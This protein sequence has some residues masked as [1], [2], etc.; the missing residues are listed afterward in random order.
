MKGKTTNVVLGIILVII[1]IGYVGN[2]FE[3]WNFKL[4]FPGWWTLFI[5]IPA[6][7]KLLRHGIKPF[8][9]VLL[10]AGILLLLNAWGIVP[11][12]LYKLIVPLCVVGLGFAVIFRGKLSGKS[13]Q[14]EMKSH[15]AVFGGSTPNYNGRPFYGAFATAIFGGVDLKLRDAHIADGAVIDALALFGG[16][17]VLVPFDVNVEVTGIPLFGGIGEPKNRP[18]KPDQPTIYVNAVAIFGGVDVK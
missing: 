1:G 15:I 18:H 2:I 6:L 3:V 12:V 17:D 11:D 7:V 14:G 9:L 4:F 16:V 13:V 8:W 5:I 10:A